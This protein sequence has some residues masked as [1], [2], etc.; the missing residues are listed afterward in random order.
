MSATGRW[1]VGVWTLPFTGLAAVTWAALAPLNGGFG[2]SAAVRQA[3]LPTAVSYPA[4]SLT[5][6]V[7]TRDVFRVGRRAAAVLY[8]PMRAVQP[9]A[10]AMPKPVLT[11]VGLVAG[12]EPAAL[13]EGFPGIQGTRVVRVGDVV[14]GLRV[15]SISGM[16]VRI[17]G[18]DTVW[19][20]TVRE[21][22]RN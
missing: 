12:S 10:D 8:D 17:A 4:E 21:P 3:L 1:A 19:T 18:M 5:R 20:L 11:L 6:V 22:W 7:I 14:A 9:V 2:P 16:A 13:V 15:R